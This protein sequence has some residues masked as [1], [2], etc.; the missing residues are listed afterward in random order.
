MKNKTKCIVTKA[1]AKCQCQSCINNR[2]NKTAILKAFISLDAIKLWDD[3]E[4]KWKDAFGEPL[5]EKTK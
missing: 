1:K 2:K 3:L 4:V 5:E